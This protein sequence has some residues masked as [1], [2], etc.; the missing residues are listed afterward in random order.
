MPACACLLVQVEAYSNQIEPI[1]E[2]MKVCADKGV[3]VCAALNEGPVPYH[4][5]PLALHLRP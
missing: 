5:A 1:I 2:S 4:K 3:S